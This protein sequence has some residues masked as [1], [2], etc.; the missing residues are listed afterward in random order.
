MYN[1]K[2]NRKINFKTYPSTFLANFPLNRNASFGH[3]VC[4]HTRKKGVERVG[5]AGENSSNV[6]SLIGIQG[7][8]NFSHPDQES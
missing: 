1:I 8:G 4:I 2:F 7:R 5:N 6:E 3:V